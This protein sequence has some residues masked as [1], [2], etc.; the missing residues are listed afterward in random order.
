M[1][2]CFLSRQELCQA[3]VKNVDVSPFC[4]KSFL[5]AMMESVETGVLLRQNGGEESPHE[6]RAERFGMNFPAFMSGNGMFMTTTSLKIL[7]K[8]K[9]RRCLQVFENLVLE[10]LKRHCEVEVEGVGTFSVQVIA[11]LALET[12]VFPLA[13][14]S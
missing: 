4:A 3:L 2:T 7:G 9:A 10:H 5:D 11:V 1:T 8:R 14:A 12:S 13:T 6:F